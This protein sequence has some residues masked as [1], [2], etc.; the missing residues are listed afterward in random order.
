L[1]RERIRSRRASLN[2]AG[3]HRQGIRTTYST[4][5]DVT[6]AVEEWLMTV[7]DRYVVKDEFQEFT[8]TTRRVDEEAHPARQAGPW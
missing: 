4:E 5:A 8:A 7:T 6:A 2:R 1:P 3:A